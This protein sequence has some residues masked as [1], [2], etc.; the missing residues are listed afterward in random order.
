MTLARKS[1]SASQNRLTA[2][3]K[4]PFGTEG[5]PVPVD[6]DNTET[7]IIGPL[8]ADM[9][10]NSACLCALVCD[11]CINAIRHIQ[12]LA[13]GVANPFLPR[14]NAIRRIGKQNRLQRS[15]IY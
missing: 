11:T 8:F 13:I 5:D 12:L 9:L 6:I 1:T 15:V 7:A 10:C 2:V 3:W 14:K 4:R